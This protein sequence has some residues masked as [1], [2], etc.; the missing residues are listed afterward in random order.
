[1]QIQCKTLFAKHFH[2]DG[3]HLSCAQ[4]C[5]SVSSLSYSTF[6]LDVISSADEK[7]TT[8]QDRQTLQNTGAEYGSALNSR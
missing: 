5:S 2:T 1:M 6:L 3:L 4:P 8:T 7:L